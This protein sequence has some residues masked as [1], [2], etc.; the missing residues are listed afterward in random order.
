MQIDSRVTWIARFKPHGRKLP[1]N[2]SKLRVR[3][4]IIIG[5]RTCE[6]G[7]VEFLVYL[8]L[9]SGPWDHPLTDRIWVA[10]A[11]LLKWAAHECQHYQAKSPFELA[12]CEASA[13][14]KQ[15]NATKRKIRRIVGG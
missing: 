4:G 5:E 14:R 1:K 11:E 10:K 7:E 8:L 3:T 2:A 15:I 13:D 6:N 9:V 12:R